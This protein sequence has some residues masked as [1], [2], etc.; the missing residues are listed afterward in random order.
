MYYLPLHLCFIS[1]I[2]RANIEY[3]KPFTGAHPRVSKSLLGVLFIF[4]YF[5]LFLSMIDIQSQFWEAYH[6]RAKMNAEIVRSVVRDTNP[7]FIYFNDGAHTT[8][9]DYPIRQVFK[10]ATNDQLLAVNMIL[11]GPI[12]YLFLRPSDWL[13]KN[14]QEII[15]MGA[16]IIN[17]QYKFLGVV[18]DQ[19]VIVY[20]LS[21]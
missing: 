21:N 7:K 11:P 2:V 15:Q 6:T 17:D 13:F 9:T 3:L 12:E 1:L 4:I 18:K 10:D 20:R 16:P 19:Q 14:N 5:P 8:F